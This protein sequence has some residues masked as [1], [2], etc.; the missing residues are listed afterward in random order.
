MKQKNV[1]RF[2]PPLCYSYDFDITMFETTMVNC[3]T[4]SS[5]VAF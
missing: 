2:D 3:R 5:S 1:M 4:L